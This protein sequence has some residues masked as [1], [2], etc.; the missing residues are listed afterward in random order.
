MNQGSRRKPK[1]C[2]Y[3]AYNNYF[4]SYNIW[5]MLNYIYLIDEID[6]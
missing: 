2:F 1:P 4:N 6:S 5:I 3:F